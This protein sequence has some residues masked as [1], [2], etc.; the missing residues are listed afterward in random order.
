M[1]TEFLTS[2]DLT[3]DEFVAWMDEHKSGLLAD[4]WEEFRQAMQAQD[5]E[6]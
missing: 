1:T 4:L 3:N 5:S 6:S 2:E